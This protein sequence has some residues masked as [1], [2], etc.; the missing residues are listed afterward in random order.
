M[1]LAPGESK[2]VTFSIRTED[3]AY[4]L[5]DDRFAATAGPVE[6]MTG[7]NA[8]DVRTGV[9]DYRPPRDAELSSA[10]TRPSPAGSPPGR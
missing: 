1:A 10:G 5:S 6:V 8:A 7:P 2:T 9:F 3:F 4:W